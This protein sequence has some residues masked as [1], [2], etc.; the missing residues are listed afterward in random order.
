MTETGKSGSE[1]AKG[2][3]R[4][5][6][7]LPAAAGL[8]VVVGI[9]VAWKLRSGGDAQKPGTNAQSTSSGA[10]GATAASG[11]GGAP[12]TGPTRPGV[13]MQ[14]EHGER[15]DE[16]DVNDIKPYPVENVPPTGVPP[17]ITEEDIARQKAEDEAARKAPLELE[18]K[19]EKA[20]ASIPNLEAA[21]AQIEKQADDAARAGRTQEAQEKR[22][23]VT[24]M[25]ER[26]AKIRAAVEA[27]T[28]P[29]GPVDEL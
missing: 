18:E 26:I 10:S 3:S 8:L 24:R 16:H 7:W 9:V 13:P 21:A 11:G 6:A 14:V 5:P 4:R 29:S 22:V 25:R 2:A 23:R 1:P 28:D 15:D 19:I 20:R 12:A 27:G 17:V